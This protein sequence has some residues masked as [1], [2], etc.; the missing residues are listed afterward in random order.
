LR[1]TKQAEG[2]FTNGWVSPWTRPWNKMPEQD[3]EH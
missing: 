2:A 3:V 1:K